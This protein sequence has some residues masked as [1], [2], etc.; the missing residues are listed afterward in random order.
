LNINTGQLININT[1]IEN[2]KETLTPMSPYG[3]WAQQ[4]MVH[5]HYYLNLKPW[6]ARTLYVYAHA[7]LAESYSVGLQEIFVSR[8]CSQEE[9]SFFLPWQ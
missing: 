1:A 2:L 7:D 5:R 8:L 4:H 9:N 6:S 3:L